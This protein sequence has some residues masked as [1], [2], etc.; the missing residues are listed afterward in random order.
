MFEVESIARGKQQKKIQE[1]YT[2]GPFGPLLQRGVLVVW[3]SEQTL[4]VILL[5]FAEEL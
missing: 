1:I 2:F 4:T 5:W 3:Q